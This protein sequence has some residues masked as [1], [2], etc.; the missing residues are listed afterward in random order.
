DLSKPFGLSQRGE[1]NLMTLENELIKIQL[2]N[3]GGKVK[4]VELKNES[5]FDDSPLYLVE[6]DNN[7][8]GFMFNTSGQ[9]INTNDLYFSTTS[10]TENSL[11]LRL[12]YN[13]D[14]YLEYIYSLQPGSY[15]LELNVHAVGIQ[16]LIDLK[17][18]T[19]LLNWESTLLQKEPNIKS[20]R[21]KSTIFFRN[22][23]GEVDH[24]SETSDDQEKIEKNKVE[25]IAFKQHFFSSILSSKQPFE[26]ADFSVALQ[27]AEG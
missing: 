23:E 9:N 3:K 24:L 26:N 19:I 21:E 25:W 20:E 4:S 18:K 6:G 10:S 12:N 16:N 13:T 15:N 8:F 5:N 22:N 14:K 1:E 7:N 27:T 17:Q 2:T 11:T